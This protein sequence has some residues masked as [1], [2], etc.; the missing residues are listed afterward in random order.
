MKVSV[1]MLTDHAIKVSNLKISVCKFT[2]IEMDQ[3]TKG[4]DFNHLKKFFKVF[5]FVKKNVVKICN[6]L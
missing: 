4:C 5:F 6:I 3:L 1:T 2:I